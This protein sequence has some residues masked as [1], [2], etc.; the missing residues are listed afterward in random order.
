MIMTKELH[1][2]AIA[3]NI[4][5]GKTTLTGLLAAHYGWQPHYETP[6]S[7]PY[8]GDFYENMQHWSFHMQIY[9]LNHRFQQI[10]DIRK[11]IQPVIQDRT[12]FED[13][14]IFAPNLHDMGLMSGRDFRLYLNLY[15]TIHQLIAPPDLLIYLR[16]GIPTLVTQIQKRGRSYEDSIRLDYLKKLNDRYEKWI[17]GYDRG[18]L[19]IIDVDNLNYEDNTEDLGQVIARIDAECAGIFNSAG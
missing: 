8:I 6:E 19:I 2:I 1:H 4:G 12:I 16:A 9:Y 10:L 17:E 5:A 15:D 3:G 7:N 13:A 11:G 18:S 14:H